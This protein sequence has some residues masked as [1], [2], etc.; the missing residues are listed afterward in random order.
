MCMVVWTL[1]CVL[2]VEEQ[3]QKRLAL[4]SNVSRVLKVIP[5]FAA[6]RSV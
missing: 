3:A 1:A 5:D 2:Q 6:Q 4:R